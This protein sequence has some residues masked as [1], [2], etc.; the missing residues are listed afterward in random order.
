MSNQKISNKNRQV[1]S[2]VKVIVV[3]AIVLVGLANVVPLFASQVHENDLQ[4]PDSQTPKTNNDG[5]IE[6]GKGLRTKDNTNCVNPPNGP[7]IC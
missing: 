6:V 3:T 4:K 1:V 5:G 7:M 2:L